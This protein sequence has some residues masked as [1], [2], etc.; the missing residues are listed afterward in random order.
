MYGKG[1]FE[2]CKV[3]NKEKLFKNSFHIDIYRSLN[4]KIENAVIAIFKEIKRA[5]V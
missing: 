4:R 5:N 3:H 1:L 2:V